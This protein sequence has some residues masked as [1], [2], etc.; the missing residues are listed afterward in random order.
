M[1]TDCEELCFLDGA[2]IGLGLLMFHWKWYIWH[3]K[4]GS[5]FSGLNFCPING[6]YWCNCLAFIAKSLL[7]VGWMWDF[8]CKDC[9]VVGNNIWKLLSWH[10]YSTQRNLDI[11]RCL[12][13]SSPF[14]C[15]W[16]QTT[17]SFMLEVPWQM[18][19]FI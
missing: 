16:V 8:L 6:P 10:S 4:N 9:T 5:Y 7:T 12:K 1:A 19:M 11:T 15:S 18:H 3:S 13:C 2:V 14:P 17:I